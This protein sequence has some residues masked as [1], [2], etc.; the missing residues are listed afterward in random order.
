[1]AAFPKVKLASLSLAF[2]V[3]DE[4]PKVRE[5]SRLLAREMGF[6]PQNLVAAQLIHGDNI[7]FVSRIDAGR[8]AFSW[9]GAMPVAH[10]RITW[11]KTCR[12]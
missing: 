9:E 4:A 1:M 11:E 5:N 6:K 3:E 8:G 7:H 12:S 10:A 2:H